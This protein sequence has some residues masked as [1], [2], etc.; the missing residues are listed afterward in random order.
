MHRISVRPSSEKAV[1]WRLLAATADSL[2]IPTAEFH[3][4]VGT[5]GRRPLTACVFS[6]PA[7]E[8]RSGPEREARQGLA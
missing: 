3:P 7:S 1:L 6:R 8:A 5:E 4:G 2:D